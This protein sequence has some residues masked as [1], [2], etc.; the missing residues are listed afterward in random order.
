MA[1][2]QYWL[3]GANWG[4]E[5]KAL[6]FVENGVWI[7]GKDEEDVQY[8]RALGMAKGDRIAIKRMPGQYKGLLIDHVGI[9]K[10]VV[11]E[12]DLVVCTVD[13][14]ATELDRYF[15]DV[16]KYPHSVHKLGDEAEEWLGKVFRL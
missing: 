5:N 11:T 8:K 14:V 6:E 15:E 16:P 10:G 7:L 2:S 12:T 3:V 1:N 13:W 9:I 4:G